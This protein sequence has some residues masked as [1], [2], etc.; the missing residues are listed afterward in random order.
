MFNNLKIKTRLWLSFGIL[1]LAMAG[2]GSFAIFQM[3]E[4]TTTATLL[5]NHPYT[6]GKAIREATINLKQMR[7]LTLRSAL[8]TD[9]VELDSTLVE[10]DALKEQNRQLHVIIKERFLGDLQEIEAFIT[11]S[12]KHGELRDEAI[13]LLK[14][15]NREQAVLFLL[16]SEYTKQFE[17][18][19]RHIKKIMK[20]GNDKAEAF[21]LSGNAQAHNSYRWTL[22]VLIATIILSLWMG[23]TLAQAVNRPLNQAVAIAKAITA[24]TL[25]NEIEVTSTNETGQLLSALST[26]QSQLW[27]RFE[28]DKR[29]TEE[30]NTVTHAASQGDFNKRIHLENKTGTFKVLG[31]SINQVLEFNQSAIKDLMR[32]F[33]AVAQGDLTKTITNDYSGELAQLKQDANVTVLKLTEVTEEINTVTHAASQGDFSKRVHLQNKTGTFKLLGESI[34]QV[35]E[36]NQMAVKDL[37]RVFSAVAQ[38]NLTEV[39]T[40]SYSGELAKL[41]ND[42]NT[43]VLKLTEVTEEISTVTHTASQGDFSKRISLEGKTGTFKT[44][45]ESINQVLDFNQLAITDLMRVFSAVAQGDLMETITNNYSGELAQLKHDANA[46]VQK[47]TEVMTIIKQ[48]AEVVS[49]A[50]QEISKGNANLSERSTQ[51]AASLE[52]TAASM[53]QMTGTVQQ[54]AENAKQANQLAS[55]AKGR[56]EQGNQVVRDAVAAI[57]EINRSSKKITEIISVIDEIAFQTNLLALNAAVEAARAGEYGRGFAVVATEV[58]TLAQRS[59]AAAKEIKTLIQDS[60]GKVDEGTKLAN[61]SGQALEEIVTAVKKVSDIIAEIA[62][63]ST[64]QSAG[65]EQVNKAISQMDQMVEQNS[66]LVEQAAAASESMKEQAQELSKQVAFFKMGETLGEREFAKVVN[67]LPAF[68][69]VRAPVRAPVK[70]EVTTQKSQKMEKSRAEWEDF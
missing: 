36:F 38:G 10:V 67:T 68:V 65:I 17:E 1:I 50:A 49:T 12:G 57:N 18:L 44:I 27:E 24:G 59:A 26:M 14:T 62:A 21:M 13:N 11:L 22:G 47:L 20:F 45:G 37:M 19:E 56:A 53:E 48:S 66:A 52:E 46:T 31:D 40:N 35:L 9:N 25:N 16:G 69:P 5:Y 8:F 63:A 28:E 39:I 34:N 6:A 61:Q 54:N 51:Q 30:I 55:S 70:R 23:I 60:N 29:I 3:Y 33:S 15:G 58:R 32:V 7:I 43:T 64:E 41:K 4:L 2:M 42:A